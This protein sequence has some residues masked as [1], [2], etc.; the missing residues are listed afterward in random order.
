MNH[1]PIELTSPQA[2]SAISEEANPAA[3]PTDPRMQQFRAAVAADLG[4]LAHLHDREL[5]QESAASLRNG[6]FAELLALALP[7]TAAVD[8]F[9]LLDQGIAELP[10]GG[11]PSQL[12]RWAADYAD[13]YLHHGARASPCESV[14]L[15]EDGL[16]MQEPMFQVRD[17][18]RRYGLQV[19]DWRMRTDDHLVCQLQFLGTLFEHP[20]ESALHDAATFLDEHTLRWLGQFAGRVSS[21]CATP[22]YAGLALLTALYLDEV[23][24]VLERLLEYPRPTAEALEERLRGR[25]PPPVSCEV[26]FVPGAAPS[27]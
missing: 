27:W 15:D 7:S 13:I 20:Q 5:T 25:A 6:P 2:G 1:P 21:R 26:P 8:A 17:W 19:A 16:A 10:L 14:W 12:D 3:V 4:L 11:D 24:G 22:F 23:R 18:Y 9:A